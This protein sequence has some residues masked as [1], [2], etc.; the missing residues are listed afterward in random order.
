[1]CIDVIKLAQKF[2]SFE[3]Y[4]SETE[5]GVMFDLAANNLEFNKLAETLNKVQTQL[6][7]GEDEPK[8]E[9]VEEIAME[10]E[11]SKRIELE[12]VTIDVGKLGKGDSKG[13]SNKGEKNNRNE[14]SSKNDNERNVGKGQDQR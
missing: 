9:E 4:M 10:E 2:V 8:V 5:F 12:K 1:M 14:N 13:Q 3:I 11:V 7:E 6:N